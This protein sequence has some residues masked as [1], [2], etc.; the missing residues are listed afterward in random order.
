[1]RYTKEQIQ[2]QYK[3][4][5]EKIQDMMGA[6]ETVDTVLDIGKKHNMHIDQL[7]ALSEEVSLVLYGLEKPES[8]HGNLRK[9]LGLSE[10]EANLI[11]YE[12][13]QRILL[14][15]REE[16]KKLYSPETKKEEKDNTTTNVP[17]NKV[18]DQPETGDNKIV[19]DPYREAV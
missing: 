18:A 7:N 19:R 13:N 12:I 3:I 5:P 6:T 10:D 14:P 1:M 16:I 8:F 2:A 9:Y 17:T 4:L 11:T 15:L